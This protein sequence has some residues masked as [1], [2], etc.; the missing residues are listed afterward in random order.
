MFA[1]DDE[2]CMLNDMVTN[3]PAGAAFIVEWYR[4]Q[5]GKIGSIRAVFDPRPFEP[6]FAA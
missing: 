6:L 3:S 2:V 1:E 5:N 4:V